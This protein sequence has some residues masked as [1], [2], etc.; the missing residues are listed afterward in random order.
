MNPKL[1]RCCNDLLLIAAYSPQNR[2]S[3]HFSD[4]FLRFYTQLSL[5]RLTGQILSDK[6]GPQTKEDRALKP[7]RVTNLQI[8][9]LD[10]P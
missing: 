8:N 3:K 10:G 5:N 4:T 6:C 1:Y 9:I 2:Q 7:A